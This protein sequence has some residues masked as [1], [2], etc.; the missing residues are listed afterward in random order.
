MISLLVESVCR[1]LLV[2]LAVWVG[3]R[4]FRVRHVVAEKAAWGMVLAAALLMP[5]V[6][7][8]AARWTAL[9]VGIGVVLPA[10]SQT[11]LQELQA[12]IQAKS[13]SGQ[14][15]APVAAKPAGE[16]ETP[17]FTTPTERAPQARESRFVAHASPASRVKTFAARQVSAID[18]A[19][20]TSEMAASVPTVSPQ[21]QPRTFV[22]SPS[23][24]LLLY[25][26]VTAVL[27]TRLLFGL[28]VALRL[29]YSARPIEAGRG[30]AFPALL[31]VRA[32][33][34]VASPVTIGSGVVLPA[35]YADWDEEKLRIVLAHENSH[36]RQGDFYLQ[37]LA[38]LYA[39]CTWFS[40]LGWWIKERLSELAEAISDR[41]G[42][43][44]AVS[45]AS[46]AQ[47][48]LEFAAAP[49]PTM[50]GVAMAR[51]GSLSRR[52]ER[53]LNES[54]FSQAFVG[55]RSRILAAVLLVPVALFGATAM[56]RVQAAGQAPQSAPAA[57]PAPNATAAPRAST[58]APAPEATPDVEE[59]PAETP[60]AEVTPAQ[61]DEQAMPGPVNV[62]VAPLSP[63]A[64]PVL[65][66]VRVLVPM[67]E[68]APL[69]PMQVVAAIPRFP[70]IP[71]VSV[72]PELA[73]VAPVGTMPRVLVMAAP[74]GQEEQDKAGLSFERTLS[75]S[76]GAELSV[77]TGSGNIHLKHGSDS[78]IHV[79]GRIHVSHEGSMEEAKQI[80]AN[81]PIV[82]NGNVV[83]IGQ[84]QDHQEK[85]HGISIDYDIEAPAGIVLH[86]NSGSGD[87]VDEGVGQNSKLETGSG[88]IRASGLQG[89]FVVQTGSGNISAEQTGQGDVK[90]ETG[91]GDIEIKDIHGSFKGQTGSGNIKANGTPSAAWI[92]QTGS[93]NVE[94]WAGNAPMTLDA[95]TGSGSV[96]TDHQMMVQ[97]SMNNHHITGTING[98]GPTVH[99]QTGSGDVVVH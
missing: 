41:A 72:L 35:D 91:S 80:A 89:A 75:V 19:E 86:A 64:V 3:L 74:R 53:L 11:L 73:A 49:R 81:P 15:A 98:G 94:L 43:E 83:Q 60:E 28:L 46:Y 84:H 22:L 45:P 26:S 77:S 10:D 93:G 31:R 58:P 1:S 71:E 76:A 47:V 14:K 12:R 87:I 95:S 61:S 92:L 32:S 82:Q 24:L 65:P 30:A 78:Q 50:I 33:S 85:W 23:L 2:G 20:T 39:A 9:P 29:W 69:P 4:A 51:R 99:V 90:A 63:G 42:L 56:I 7:P 66:R 34:K 8:W 6:A 54:K 21:P 79:H 38:G 97:G 18:S 57:Q 68:V 59:T 44:Q 52:I 40:P 27:M 5:V 13:G 36:V 70:A 25:C 16:T 67:P 55:G 37:I 62:V 48:L 88:D 96:T 17:R